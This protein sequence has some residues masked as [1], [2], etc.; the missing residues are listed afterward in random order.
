[1][2]TQKLFFIGICNLIDTISTL[3]LYQTGMFEEL[4]PFMAVLLQNPVIFAI[5]KIGLITAIVIRLW[6]ER[7]DKKA[8]IA[9]NIGCWIY[10]LIALYYA[11]IVLVTAFIL[12]K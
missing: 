4:N 10:G 8:Q 11:F 2:K 1:M 5:V 3:C 6:K 7:E 12:S 9:I